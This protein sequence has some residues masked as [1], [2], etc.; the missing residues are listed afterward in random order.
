MTPFF[1][2]R[3]SSD[4]F[5]NRHALFLVI[6]LLVAGAR[7]AILLLAQRHVHSDEA[8]IGLMGKHILE[9]RYL[10]FYMY[11]Q[12][13]NAGA[14]WEAYLAAGSFAVFGVSVTALKGV[15]VALS[16]LTLAIFYRLVCRLFDVPTAALAAGVLAVMPTLLKWHFEV[17]GYSLYFLSIPILTG[18]FFWLAGRDGA[19]S[20]GSAGSDAGAS[21]RRNRRDAAIPAGVFGLLCGVSVWGLE[22]ILPLVVAYGLILLSI[23]KLR[24]GEQLAGLAGFLVG[25]L[26]A[27]VFNLLHDASNWRSVFLMK[28]RRDLPGMQDLR[29]IFLVELPMF[30]GHDTAFFYYQPATWIGWTFYG[31]SAGAMIAALVPWIVRPSRLMLLSRGDLTAPETKDLVIVLLTAAGFAAY[32]AAPIRAANFFLGGCFFLAILISRLAMRL[33][34]GR[35]IAGAVIGGT[36]VFAGG[37]AMLD[38]ARRDEVVTLVFHKEGTASMARFPGADIA[39]VQ[40]YLKERRID[41]IW[42]TVS[43]VYPMIF[44]SGESLAVSEEVFGWHREVYP[45]G[46]HRRLP[47]AETCGVYVIEA[48]SPFRQAIER[49]CQDQTGQPPVVREFGSLI[50][51][52]QAPP[53]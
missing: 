42:T 32:L 11:G 31:L 48:G 5:S 50:V 34:R 3:I 12:P 45:P 15:I 44:E 30:F 47:S 7:L 36:A 1:F 29:D 39:R 23:R 14:A 13:Y 53:A 51:I 10:P 19:C 46:V 24:L 26:P 20:A 43:F 6:F 40:N 21:S 18:L 37:A 17:R 16:L 28:T 49:H 41:A 52:E 35:G 2:R 27:I 38:V 22:L 9:G 25:Y 33:G 8:I 4:P